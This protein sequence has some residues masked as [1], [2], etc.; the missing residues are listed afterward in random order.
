MLGGG[1]G[2]VICLQHDPVASL[3]L[4]PGR[5]HARIILIRGDHF[6]AALQVQAQLHDLERLAGV[7]RDGDFFRIA[8]ER[9]RQPSP[10]RLD[11][12]IENVPHV[13]RRAQV[14]HF[15]VADL[16]VHHDLRR[17]RHAAVVQIDHVA[18]D[19]EG[20]ADVEPEILVARHSIGRAPRDSSRGLLSTKKR[21]GLKGGD[22]AG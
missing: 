17:R 21:I 5:D 12:R 19:R 13:V 4:L 22:K 18:V 11:A 14:L 1:T 3:A 20:V 16:G 8:A 6:V 15:Q 2:N 10:H 7:A 9:S